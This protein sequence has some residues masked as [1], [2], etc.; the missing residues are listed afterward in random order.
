MKIIVCLLTYVITTSLFGQ[1]VVVLDHYTQI[2]E[3]SEIKDFI[4]IA[5]KAEVSGKIK[6]GRVKGFCRNKGRSTIQNLYYA[7]HKKAN[8]LGADAM[9]IDSI[10][11]LANDSVFVEGT[12]YL[13][14]AMGRQEAES[15]YPENK[16]YVLGDFDLELGESRKVYFNG[17]KYEVPPLG[18]L[19]HQNSIGMTCAVSKGGI[20]GSSV[21]IKGRP[22]KRPVFITMGDPSVAPAVSPGGGV[23][24]SFSAGSLTPL[25]LSL[26]YFAVAILESLSIEPQEL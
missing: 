1:T 19:S 6:V 10:K 16:V 23:G 17:V 22:D 26:G 21:K 18:L 9:K 4:C 5:D 8:E 25:S 11:I 3:S 14:G 20:L 24:V 15:H 12:L 13:F 7:L 2:G